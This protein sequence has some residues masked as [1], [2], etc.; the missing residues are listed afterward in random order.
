[1]TCYILGGRTV[2]VLSKEARKAV[3]TN[4]IKQ[5]LGSDGIWCRIIFQSGGTGATPGANTEVLEKQLVGRIWKNV[6]SKKGTSGFEVILDFVIYPGETVI[7]P[8]I[9]DTSYEEIV[10]TRK[11]EVWDSLNPS[12]K[13]QLKP[14]MQVKVKGELATYLG[15]HINPY[16]NTTS[17]GN[18]LDKDIEILVIV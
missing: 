7:L 16:L 10:D 13:W 2:G 17:V 4:K 12:N 5:V 3:P 8:G 14:G 15:E 1:M 11:K 6:Q 9:W 18:V